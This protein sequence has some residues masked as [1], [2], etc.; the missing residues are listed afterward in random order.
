MI[1]VDRFQA[2]AVAEQSAIAAV[3]GAVKRAHILEEM[4]AAAAATKVMA[5]E[6]AA[7]AAADTEKEEKAAAAAATAAAVATAAASV[8]A[9]AKVA[10][11]EEAQ[12]EP[13]LYRTAETAAPD[14]TTV[15]VDYF[16]CHYFTNEYSMMNYYPA[17]KRYSDYVVAADWRPALFTRYEGDEATEERQS[18]DRLGY[19]YQ[20]ALAAGNDVGEPMSMTLAKAERH[21]SS[22]G[23]VGFSFKV[24]P[25]KARGSWL[26]ID[27][28]PEVE[29]FF[30]S[31]VEGDNNGDSVQWQTFFLSKEQRGPHED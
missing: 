3:N 12:R 14:G 26:E 6:E 13:F 25:K 29:V 11:A 18:E 5:Q 16:L 23:A 20:G 24:L 15:K 8:A 2:P 10:Q 19:Y 7:A 22:I 21:C 28:E 27:K 30:K 9:E 31:S 4:A 17:T 1:P